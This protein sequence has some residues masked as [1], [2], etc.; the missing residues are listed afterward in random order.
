MGYFIYGA[1]RV[2]RLMEEMLVKNGYAVEAFLDVNAENMHYKDYPI[3]RPDI[4]NIPENAEIIVALAMK[5]VANTTKGLLESKGYKNV[6]LWSDKKLRE[7]LCPRDSEECVR[8]AFAS[9]CPQMEDKNYTGKMCLDSLTISLT[10]KCSL[11][12]KF[13]AALIPMAK[14]KKIFKDLE[15]EK[16]KSAMGILEQYVEE[17]KEYSLAGG[18][19]LLNKDICTILEIIEHSK[20]RFR[21]I[22]ILTNGTWYDYGGFAE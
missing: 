1:G 4:V 11:N 15:I 19:P 20:I 7:M 17:I 2:G 22:N 8:C 6:V 12:C 13:C 10:T 5:N 3:I 18:E 21:V 16:F 14:K 9:V